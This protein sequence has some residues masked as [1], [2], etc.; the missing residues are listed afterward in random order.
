MAPKNVSQGGL[1]FPARHVV[2]PASRVR[3]RFPGLRPAFETLATVVWCHEGSAP[4]DVGV[5]FDDPRSEFSVRMIEQVC[6]I[7]QYKRDLR[8]KEGRILTG[9]EAAR[10]WIDRF[11]EGFPR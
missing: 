3:I 5:C 9:E 6:H 1:C 8:E 7:E 11:A 2:A 10:E 4:H